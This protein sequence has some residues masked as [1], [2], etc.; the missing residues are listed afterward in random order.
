MLFGQVMVGATPIWTVTSANESGHGGFEIV[1]RSLTWP[2]PVRCVHVAFGVE[3]FGLKVP[4][5]PAV[6]MVHIPVP[7]VGVLPPSGAVVP[8]GEMV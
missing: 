2:L 8:P 3:A 1:H 5:N 7:E 4:V 6:A